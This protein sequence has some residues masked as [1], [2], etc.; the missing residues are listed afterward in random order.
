MTVIARRAVLTGRVQGV[1]F[2]FFA[3]RA[4]YEAGVKGWVRNRP[5][6]AVE[7][8][9]EGEEEAVRRY[10]EKLR[11]GPRAAKVAALHEEEAPA[12]GCATFEITG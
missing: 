12:K 3:E 7:T 11:T 4:A 2:R 8:F 1:G 9:A 10:L 5:D 6:G